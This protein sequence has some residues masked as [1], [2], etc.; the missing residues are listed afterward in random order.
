MMKKYRNKKY[1]LIASVSLLMLAFF[2]FSLPDPLFNNP[3]SKVLLDKN[4]KIIGVKIAK[5]EQWRMSILTDIPVKYKK[6]LIYFEDEYFNYHLGVNPVSLF[7]AVGQYI[8]KGRIVSGA[9]TISMQV[10]RL[11]RGNRSRT[12]IE[13]IKEIFLATRL[14]LSYSKEEILKFYASN[15]PYGGNIVGLEAASWKYFRRSPMDLSWSEAALLAVLPNSPS[16]I[17]PGRNTDILRAKRDRLL[18]KLQINN[19]IDSLSC[20]LA[21]Q[22]PITKLRY[23]F[24]RLAPHLLERAVNEHKEDYIKSTV[25]SDIQKMVN[26]LLN[27]HSKEQQANGINNMA[28]I[29]IDIES[30]NILSYVGNSKRKGKE[31]NGNMVDIITSERSSGSIIKP[32]LYALLQQKGYILPNTIIPDIP[33]K[34]G[35]YAPKNFSLHFDGAVSASRALARSLNIPSV[36]MLQMMT[37]EQFYDYLP[38]FGIKTV[39]RGADHYGLSI[40]LGGAEVTLEQVASAYAG[41]ARIIKHYNSNDGA[42][43]KG[44]FAKARYIKREKQEEK[45]ECVSPPVINAAASWLT[46]KALLQVKRPE[47]ETGWDSFLSANKI[48]WKTGTSYGFRDAWAVGLNSKYVV[49][50]WAGNADGEGRPGLLGV[51]SAAPLMFDVFSNLSQ[52]EWFAQPVEEMEQVIVCK[53]SGYRASTNCALKDTLW[54]MIEGDKTRTCPFCKIIHLDKN[55]NYRVNSICEDVQNM[56][57]ESYFILPPVMEWYYKKI[58]PYY[59]NLPPYRDD[60]VSNDEKAMD[61]IYPEKNTSV[62]IPKGMGGI[63]GKVIFEVAHSINN[64]TIHWHIDNIYIR[65]TT[66]THQIEVQPSKGKH[67]LTLIDEFG[68]TITRKFVVK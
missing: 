25:D 39:D 23:S 38:K 32:M 28:A 22:E 12:V 47:Q 30:G 1:Y 51:K 49:G 18:D 65:S 33:T 9:S 46:F 68:N 54:V 50:V 3:K 15:A 36:K 11:S 55:E 14:E 7:R 41:M 53:H 10:I 17:F 45:K 20:S 34:F 4:E 16:L 26:S 58:N 29:V 67:I 61:I 21:K 64:A 2:Y 44:D 35:S 59:K 27:K 37:V 63:R 57:H 62:F 24:P 52:E 19:V 40:I 6:A 5:D 31:D 8:S 60:C 48:A 56:R 13:K 43:F 66:S 42:Y